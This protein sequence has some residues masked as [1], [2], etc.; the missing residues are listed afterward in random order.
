MAPS[1][2]K[3]ILKAIIGGLEEVPA[4]P[5]TLPRSMEGEWKVIATDLR[6]RRL[7]THSMLGALETYMRA[8]WTAREATKA[9]EE[10]GIVILAKDRTAKTNPANAMLL[11]SQEIIARLAGDLGLTP[12]ARSR[13]GATAL[14]PATE[15]A[16][17]L[18]L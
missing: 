7:L 14:K 6:D 5:S 10:H 17:D 1:G 9:I 11:K 2:V 18:G 16:N 15:D 12:A 13:S 3:P 4:L 8:L